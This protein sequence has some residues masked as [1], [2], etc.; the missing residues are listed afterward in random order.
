MLINVKMPTIVG[1]LTFIS[2]INTTFGSLKV[3]KVFIFQH[4]ILSE[5]LNLKQCFQ[6]KMVYMF[7]Q[8][9]IESAS[10]PT[11]TYCVTMIQAEIHQLFQRRACT[12]NFGQTLKL[13]S[14]VVT[15]VV[16]LNI[17]S[18]SSKSN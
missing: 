14:S 6:R 8:P 3:R 1:I 9:Q 18:R 10:M 15:R 16:T 17:R 13:Q 2:I 7:P 12:N 4:F 11:A 5:Q